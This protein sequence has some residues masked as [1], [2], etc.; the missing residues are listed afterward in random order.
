MPP[1][2]STPKGLSREQIEQWELAR[3]TEP[4]YVRNFDETD[5]Q[6]RARITLPHTHD[7]QG[8]TAFVFGAFY[9]LEGCSLCGCL[10]G[11]KLD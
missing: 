9:I 10:Q 8:T 5:A 4:R 7:W 6:F 3:M 1:E 2:I 11:R